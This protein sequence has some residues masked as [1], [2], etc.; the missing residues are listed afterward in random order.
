ML[1]DLWL[2]TCLDLIARMHLCHARWTTGALQWLS[3]NL[4]HPFGV[5]GFL[6]LQTLVE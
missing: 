3:K 2:P 4:A 6:V 5:C 1:V